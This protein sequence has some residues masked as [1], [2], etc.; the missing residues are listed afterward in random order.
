[1][2]R[3]REEGSKR[4]P[5]RWQRERRRGYIIRLV[6]VVAIISILGVVGYGYYDTYVKPWRQPIVRVND[7]VFDMRYYVRMLRLWGAG[8]DINQDREMANWMPEVIQNYELMRQAAK[9]IDITIS[10]E[11][12]EEEIRE[13]LTKPD[14]ELTDEELEQRYREELERIEL[15]DADFKELGIEPMLLE[16]EL[17]EHIGKEK[18]L[19]PQ[20]HIEVEAMLVGTWEEALEKAELWRDG[21]DFEQLVKRGEG[22]DD[23]E[24][25]E[26]HHFEEWLPRD[27]ESPAFDEVAFSLNEN[28]ISEPVHDE[29]EWSRGG[30]WLFQVL[31]RD[32]GDEANEEDDKV[33]LR[34]ILLDSKA[35]AAEIAGELGAEPDDETFVQ[36][37][38]ENSLDYASKESSGDLGWLSLEDV[39]SR[40]EIDKDELTELEENKLSEPI[41]S[42]DIYKQGG[43]WLI[44]VL[45]INEEMSL[46]EEHRSTLV[47]KAFYEWFDK[48]KEAANLLEN[49]LDDSKLFWALE[50]IWK[51]T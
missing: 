21:E 20:E 28:D 6:V 41:Y 18:V 34:G 50:Q 2:S 30:W 48:Q 11:S 23:E 43:Y 12:I 4:Q 3:K 13:W 1:M 44:K 14:E 7:R 47:S 19:D 8:Q 26:W 22:E 45:D 35:K 40:L 36:F 16:R 42:E 46:S 51:G 25:E 9:K 37:V 27:I 5:P 39:E 33:H 31:E 10:D 49:Y 15:S 38:E 24:E 32:L 29:A 17:R